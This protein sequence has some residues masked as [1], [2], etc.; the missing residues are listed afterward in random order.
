MHVDDALVKLS[1]V[2]KS[3]SMSSVQ[4]ARVAVF[5]VV[6]VLT[7]LSP[8]TRALLAT[9]PLTSGWPTSA[10]RATRRVMTPAATSLLY[11]LKARVTSCT[12]YIDHLLRLKI[13]VKEWLDLVYKGIG[14]IVEKVLFF[15]H[16]SYRPNDLVEVT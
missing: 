8:P 9:L 5:S 10:A 3:Y 15:L 1:V 7:G 4:S 6:T 16:P 12:L 13:F 2:R 11:A 14:D